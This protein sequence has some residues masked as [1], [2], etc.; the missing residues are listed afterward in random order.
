MNK[1]LSFLFLLT[2]IAS[3]DDDYE[4]CPTGI[5]YQRN[6]DLDY[7]PYNVGDEIFL[8]DSLG[9]RDTLKLSTYS[10]HLYYL[11]GASCTE[12]DALGIDISL[13]YN[14]TEMC[15]IHFGSQV[16]SGFFAQSFD[17]G[18]EFSALFYGGLVKSVSNYEFDGI[19]YEKVLEISLEDT[20]SDIEKIVVAKNIGFLFFT[21]NGTI[22]KV[23]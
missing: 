12:S 11:G 14:T 3:C 17:C 6:S 1:L 5:S 21:I 22:R 23:V 8:I 16:H 19:N 4:R 9:N 7:F 18:G 10:T 2:I 20:N 13:N 15:N